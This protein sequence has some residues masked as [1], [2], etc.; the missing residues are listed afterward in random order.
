M[1]TARIVKDE[2]PPPYDGQF[3]TAAYAQP[4]QQ[5]FPQQQQA[6]QPFPQQQQPQP[7]YGYGSGY[8]A[9]V[10]NGRIR[11]IAIEWTSMPEQIAF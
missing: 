7:Q 6:Q 4:T 3:N 9:Q 1:E 10:R 8:P 2:Q 11:I 5:P